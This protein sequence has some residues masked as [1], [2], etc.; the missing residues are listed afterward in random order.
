VLFKELFACRQ[1]GNIE[2]VSR[3]NGSRKTKIDLNIDFYVLV[4][5]YPLSDGPLIER[6]RK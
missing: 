3:A 6:M 1:R 5:L 2:F 4:W